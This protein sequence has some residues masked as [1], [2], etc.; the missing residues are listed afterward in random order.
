MTTTQTSKAHRKA[1]MK[2]IEIL[3]QEAREC[4]TDAAYRCVKES[5]DDARRQLREALG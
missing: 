1:L 2:R 3:S 4:T 5:I